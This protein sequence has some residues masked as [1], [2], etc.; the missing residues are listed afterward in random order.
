MGKKSFA[1]GD[2]L[3][4]NMDQERAATEQRLKP[5]ADKYALAS[6]VLDADDKGEYD[7]PAP[8]E[9]LKVAPAVVATAPKPR[10]VAQIE[11]PKAQYVA[12]ADKVTT[13]KFSLHPSDLERL[14]RLQDKM[15]EYGLRYRS[16]V[17]RVAMI[18]LEQQGDEALRKVAGKLDI[19]KPGKV[20]QR[21]S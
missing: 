18:A 6:L 4:A 1:L 12:K 10:V 9:T 19:L 17:I 20:A 14:D 21:R 5:K 8:P 3:K 15:R 16:E 2:K 13:E 11:A 7:D